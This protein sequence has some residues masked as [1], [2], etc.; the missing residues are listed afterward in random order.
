MEELLRLLNRSRDLV[1]DGAMQGAECVLDRAICEAERLAK[2][3]LGELLVENE[4]LKADRG[5]LL[6]RVTV[7]NREIEHLKFQLKAASQEFSDDEYI[8]IRDAVDRLINA[9]GKDVDGDQSESSLC[10]EF[11]DEI[12]KEVISPLKI[13]WDSEENIYTHSVSHCKKYPRITQD[14]ARQIAIEFYFWWHNQPGKNTTQGFDEWFSGA[15]QK[16]IAGINGEG[17]D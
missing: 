17:H 15:G 9:V 4:A 12:I 11:I 3:G 14:I 1:I 10:S 2:T 5:P 6:E 13:E 8:C 7:A 16:T